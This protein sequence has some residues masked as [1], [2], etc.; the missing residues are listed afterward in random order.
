MAESMQTGMTKRTSRP[1]AKLIDADNGEEPELR[2]H[3]AARDRA[4][5]A[6]ESTKLSHDLTA[7]AAPQKIVHTQTA[8]PTAPT[9]SSTSSSASR[10]PPIPRSSIVFDTDAATPT[11]AVA[12]QS[13]RASVVD[14]EDTDDDNPPG[15]FSRSSIL[16]AVH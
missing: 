11:P 4:I 9:V 16:C 14:A 10:E 8:L 1:S 7:V 6:E 15:E 12:A 2:S 13:K 3:K 5:A